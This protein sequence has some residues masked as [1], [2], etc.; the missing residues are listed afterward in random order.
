MTRRLVDTDRDD[1]APVREPRPR[2]SGPGTDRP[3][4]KAR[5]PRPSAA[6]GVRLPGNDFTPVVREQPLSQ[7]DL[8]AVRLPIDARLARVFVTRA[9]ENLLFP[10]ERQPTKGELLWRRARRVYEVDTGTHMTHIEAE[11]PSRGD[12]FAFRA[13]IDLRCQVVDP[14]LLVTSGVRRLREMVAP[15]LLARLRAVTRGF[16]IAEAHRAEDAATQ[17]LGSGPLGGEYGVRVEVFIR[18]APDA[19]SLEH[20][21][22]QRRVEQFR[23]IIA[24]G[25]FQ[26]FALQLAMRPEDIGAVVEKLADERD[27]SRAALFDFVTKMLESDALERW[28]VEEQLQSVLKWLAESSHKVLTGT[29]EAR[30]VS[31]GTASFGDK[32]TGVR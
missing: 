25:D 9:G 1:D 20:A 8:L 17:E 14:V 29:D 2:E 4:G 16:D 7:R 13:V 28:Q 10:P 32:R 15:A 6:D 5:S 18:F 3:R 26:Q 24:A 27:S 22:V 23:E 12:R 19:S 21:A 31:F 30:S 11:L